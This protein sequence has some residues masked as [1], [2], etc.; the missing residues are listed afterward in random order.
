MNKSIF[1][2]LSHPIQYQSPMLKEI[3]KIDNIELTVLFCSKEGLNEYYDEQFS[4]KIKY[5]T[6]LLEGFNYKFLENLSPFPTI[7]KNFYGLINLEVIIYILKNRPNYIII[8]GWSYITHILAIVTAKIVGTKV[9]LRGESPLNQELQKN[10]I[11]LILK[12]IILK[13]ILFPLVHYFLYIGNQNKKFY[14]FFGV[15]KEQLIFSP[16]SIN[17]DFFKSK[18]IVNS[19]QK[20]ALK[21][22]LKIDRKSHLFLFVGKLTPKKRPLD[23]LHALNKCKEKNNFHL[24]IIGDGEL[25]KELLMLIEKY[26]L[27][28]K[29]TFLG[30]VNQSQLSKYYSISDSF[31][32]PSGQGETWGLVVNEAMCHGLPCILSSTVGSSFDLITKRTGSIYNEGDI[33]SLSNILDDFI[34]NKKNFDKEYIQNKIEEYS[35]EAV[36]HSIKVLL[37][38]K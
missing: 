34:G 16:Y 37:M 14:Q 7:F 28:N 23:I 10:K 5:D 12:K 13:K 32:L 18:A 35:Y 22:Q 21:N 29:V 24:L 1:Y 33:N 8:H 19:H 31:I 15:K 17:N 36:C 38:K 6:P 26:N 9:V 30:F 20:L 2:L 4:K 25:K 27:S 11:N 3:A